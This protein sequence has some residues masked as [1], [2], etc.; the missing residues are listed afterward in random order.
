MRSGSANR[1]KMIAEYV[2]AMRAVWTEPQASYEGEY[3]HFDGLETYPKPVQ[4]PLPI[5]RAGHGDAALE[6]IALFGQGWIDSSHTP[7]EIQAIMGRIRSRAESAGRSPENF[8][9][10]RQLYVSLGETQKEADDN[11]A[12]ALPPPV[13]EQSNAASESPKTEQTGAN[14]SRTGPS[15]TL[16]GTPDYVHDELRK[17]EA[18]GV[19][20]MCVI[21]YS[22]TVDAAERQMRLFA[23]EVLPRFTPD[24]AA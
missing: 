21:F 4:D 23:R 7:E 24:T 12:A 6:W 9:V 13:S 16:V 8:E 22:P 17:Y 20:D 11:F 1:S 15:R 10:A 19:T 18:A 2:A 3:V 14:R 5:L